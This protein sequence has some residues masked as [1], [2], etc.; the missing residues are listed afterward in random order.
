MT[1]LNSISKEQL[2]A[3]DKSYAGETEAITNERTRCH[4]GVIAVFTSARK[5]GKIWLTAREM[6][7]KLHMIGV[8]KHSNPRSVGD[9][10]GKHTGG[11]GLVS[12]K[13][14][15]KTQYCYFTADLK[16]K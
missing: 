4:Q 15:G 10:L 3:L 6:T 2:E 8:I 7:D 12:R 9:I 13:V 14:N 11:M 5:V 16:E 1:E